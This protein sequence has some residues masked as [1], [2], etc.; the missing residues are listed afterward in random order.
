[1][2]VQATPREHSPEVVPQGWSKHF[3]MPV[4]R[5]G[6]RVKYAGRWETVD[7]VKLRRL[8]LM[9]YL[10]DHA[11]PVAPRELEL[12]PTLFTTERM[13]TLQNLGYTHSL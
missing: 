13:P 2:Q 6:V 5:H 1:M 9:V 11:E 12:A 7:Y 10:L 8:E 4:F 3:V